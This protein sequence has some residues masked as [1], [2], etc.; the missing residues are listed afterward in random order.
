MKFEVERLLT[1]AQAGFNLITSAVGIKKDEVVVSCDVGKKLKVQLFPNVSSPFGLRFEVPID[2]PPQKPFSFSVDHS[3]LFLALS[4]RKGA[5]SMSVSNSELHFTSG[6]MKGRMPCIP[7]KSQT[8]M[9]IK[10]QKAID[11]KLFELI[12]TGVTSCT[13][14]TTNPLIYVSCKAGELK[15]MTASD[16]QMAVARYSVGK[17]TPT[18]DFALPPTHFQS[19]RQLAESLGADNLEFQFD[20]QR[21]ILQIGANC[22]ALLPTVVIDKDKKDNMEALLTILEGQKLAKGSVIDAA[23]FA[24]AL[25]NATAVSDTNTSA[26]LIGKKDAIGVEISSGHGHIQEVLAIEGTV[27]KGKHRVDPVMLK[28]SLIRFG[29]P[30]LQVHTKPP[31]FTLFESVVEDIDPPKNTSKKEKKRVSSSVLHVGR[32]VDET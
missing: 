30:V 1:P 4:G 31:A 23:K 26:L 5:I 6:R 16:Y 21:V 28:Q 18:L 13:I 27:I 3:V 20:E 12:A 11:K 24:K 10:P 15:V 25:T 17:K 9:S 19:I 2:E 22:T 7:Y 8:F 29:N 14:A 32:L